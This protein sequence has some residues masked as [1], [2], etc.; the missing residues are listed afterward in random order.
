MAVVRSV[1]KDDN[2]EITGATVMKGSNREVV[3][4]HSSTLIPLL[5][6]NNATDDDNDCES[7][8][9]INIG[10]AQVSRNS[11]VRK[12]AK[13]SRLKTRNILTND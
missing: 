9:E 7:C 3:K 4:R 10:N 6:Y 11:A 12:A 8:H 1:V 13:E 2:D 5:Q